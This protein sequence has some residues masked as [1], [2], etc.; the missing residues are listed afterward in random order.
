MDQSPAK[1]SMTYDRY[2]ST[3]LRVT[4]ALAVL[5]AVEQNESR[6]KVWVRCGRDRTPV[7]STDKMR[8]LPGG[9]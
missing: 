6:R 4:N 7:R 5:A 3:K 9:G 1:V 8:W 2:S